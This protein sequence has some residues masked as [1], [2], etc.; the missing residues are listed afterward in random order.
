VLALAQAETLCI[1]SGGYVASASTEQGAQLP[2][3]SAT[4]RVPS[5]R[6]DA[7]VAGLR[8]LAT[9]VLRE[10]RQ[11]EDVTA[12]VTDL[13]ARLRALRATEDELL[14]LLRESRAR[15]Q[16]VEDIMAVYR[17]L[18]G[19]RMQIEQHEGQLRVVREQ[20]ALSTIHLEI[21]AEGSGAALA[22]PSWRPGATL[23]AALRSLNRA[24]RGFADLLIYAVV[25][26]VPLI[27]IGYGLFW[28]GRRVA[29][30]IRRTPPR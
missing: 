5:A 24:L 17:E 13:D 29:R 23:G 26:F 14:A 6:L 8:T 27:A 3:A 11:V 22:A 10:T 18:T 25:V 19:I 9:R 21:R 15:G 2:A 16:K 7:V 4:M 1:R 20:V 28:I 12:Q 30:R